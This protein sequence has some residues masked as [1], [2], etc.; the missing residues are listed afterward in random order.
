MNNK[1]NY[2]KKHILFFCIISLMICS[3]KCDDYYSNSDKR[4]ILLDL[5]NL[6]IKVV[7]DPISRANDKLLVTFDYKNRATEKVLK[8]SLEI[9]A[10][11]ENSDTLDFISEYASEYYFSFNNDKNE[12]LTLKIKYAVDSSK[13]R[14]NKEIFLQ[15]LEIVEICRSRPFLH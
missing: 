12:K 5:F 7:P 1:N 8:E 6:E 4:R 13:T 2:R 10:I 9:I 14:I 11:L 3:C 15:D